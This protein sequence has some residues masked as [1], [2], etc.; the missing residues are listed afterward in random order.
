MWCDGYGSTTGALV[1]VRV[2]GFNDEKVREAVFEVR[3]RKRCAG[4][5]LDEDFGWIQ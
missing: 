5:R 2:D 3:E 4:V 1:A